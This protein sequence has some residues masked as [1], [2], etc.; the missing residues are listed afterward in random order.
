LK[1]SLTT[2]TES[3]GTS[4]FNDAIDPPDTTVFVGAAGLVGI[5]KFTVLLELE[6]SFRVAGIP[7]LYARKNAVYDPAL[8][9]VTI[10][11][12]VVDGPQS[13]IMG[14]P[15]LGVTV[16]SKPLGIGVP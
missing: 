12:L 16:I 7:T 4:K 5:A 2:A 11:V 10:Q 1:D 15:V 13:L 14:A 9:T 3:S 6:Y 8:V